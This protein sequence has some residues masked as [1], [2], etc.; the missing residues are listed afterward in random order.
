MAS[1]WDSRHWEDSTNVFNVTIP[2]KGKGNRIREET[3]Y[4]NKGTLVDVKDFFLFFIS[5]N[6]QITRNQVKMTSSVITA[7]TTNKT[8]TIEC[9]PQLFLPMCKQKGNQKIITVPDR[10]H[11]I[12]MHSQNK[13]AVTHT[14]IHHYNHTLL[15]HMHTSQSNSIR[16]G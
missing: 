8:P 3:G 1:S 7:K 6:I 4:T 12:K 13:M 14:L 9:D 11:R 5:K 2:D 16:R 15:K 10:R